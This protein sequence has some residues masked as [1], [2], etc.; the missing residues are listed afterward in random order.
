[1]GD[2]D[3]IN[4][5]IDASGT[6]KL[7]NFK[8]GYFSFAFGNEIALCTN[9]GYYIL[10]CDISLWIEVKKFIN[11]KKP[12]YKEILKFWLDK[13]TKYNISSWSESFED[14]NKVD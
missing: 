10:N 5:S 2:T 3:G 9:G 6:N 13:S 12:T 4:E 11:D 7:I 14:L 8:N 1:M